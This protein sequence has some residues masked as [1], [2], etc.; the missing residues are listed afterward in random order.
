MVAACLGAA[1]ASADPVPYPEEFIGIWETTT[2]LRDCETQILINQSTVRD[3]ICAGDTFEFT[4]GEYEV[5][6]TG[7]ITATT[8]DVQCEGSFQVDPDCTGNLQI[9]MDGTRTGDTW[10]STM[11][12]GTTYVGSSCPIPSSCI[13]GTSTGTRLDPNPLCNPSPVEGVT[14][15]Q[16]KHFYD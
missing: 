14:W 7:T 4:F 11:R 1:S 10:T 2:I 6:C 15:G 16:L 9:T 5:N 13:E 8:V 3:T 12:M